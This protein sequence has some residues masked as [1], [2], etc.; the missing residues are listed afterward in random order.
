MFYVRS[1]RSSRAGLS[2][3]AL[4]GCLFLAN[5]ATDAGTLLHQ[6][7]TRDAVYGQPLLTDALETN[8]PLVI[9]N[10]LLVLP[11]DYYAPPALKSRSYLLTNAEIAI[12]RTGTDVFDATYPG[13]H[14]AFAIAPHIENYSK[15]IQQHDRFLVYC[16]RSQSLEW[17]TAQLV[18]DGFTLTTRRSIGTAVLSEARRRSCKP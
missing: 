16:D 3:V 10:G 4:L 9:A 12:R 2:T 7:R 8:L 11:I 1:G 18:A 6:T 17:V 5:F 13:I 15:F 14:D